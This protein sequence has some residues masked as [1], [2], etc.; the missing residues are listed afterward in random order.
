MP[1]SLLSVFSRLGRIQSKGWI[2]IAKA[3]IA[4]QY[5]RNTLLN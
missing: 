3:A 4:R 1:F 2:H 5:V